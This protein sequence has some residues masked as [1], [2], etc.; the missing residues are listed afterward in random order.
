VAAYTNYAF[1]L[2]MAALALRGA[3][4]FILG[5]FWV[6]TRTALDAAGGL[7]PHTRTVSDD[8]AI[9][10]ALHAAGLRNRTLRRPVRLVHEPLSAAG[11]ARHLLKWLTML[12]A[13]GA[14]LYTTVALAWN[15]LALAIVAGLLGWAAAAVPPPLPAAAVGLVVVA[16]C[17]VVLALN[18]SVYRGL[19][20][21]RFLG[22]LLAYEACIAPWLFL[23]AAFRRHVTWRG[24]RYRLGPRG[25]I[26]DA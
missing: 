11:G 3:P 19:A 22:T 12:R 6:T 9:G 16:R 10:R 21:T 2:A 20:P 7:E 13:E 1:A 25:V 17:A 23:G 5:G 18:R 24:R 26:V 4:R 14:G 8:A 15:P